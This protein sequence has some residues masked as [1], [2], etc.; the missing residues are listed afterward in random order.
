M[1]IYTTSREEFL[2]RAEQI[3]YSTGIDYGEGDLEFG[4]VNGTMCYRNVIRLDDNDDGITAIVGPWQD[5]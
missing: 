4:F 5:L 3:F 2:R 1:A